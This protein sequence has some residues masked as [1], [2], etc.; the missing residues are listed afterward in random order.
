[1]DGSSNRQTDQEDLELIQKRKRQIWMIVAVML[2]A[3]CIG[4]A[5]LLALIWFISRMILP[6]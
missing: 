4:T 5:G 2:V 3:F 1:M 6:Q